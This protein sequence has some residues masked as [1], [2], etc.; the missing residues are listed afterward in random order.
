MRHAPVSCEI[1]DICARACCL[2]FVFFQ[3]ADGRVRCHVAPRMMRH[4]SP[5]LVLR[6]IS[7]ARTTPPAA[8]Q[9]S[10]H[11]AQPSYCNLTAHRACMRVSRRD[12]VYR[13]RRVWCA[14]KCVSSS[15]LPFSDHRV[16]LLRSRFRRV[17]SRLPPHC[18]S[19]RP[20][21]PL[22]FYSA[23][24]CMHPVHRPL[25]VDPAAYASALPRPHAPSVLS[26]DSQTACAHRCLR[27]VVR[28]QVESQIKG[29]FYKS[30]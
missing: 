19:A 22:A 9:D 2:V 17:S 5:V 8:T 13:C 3:A 21:C 18:P 7:M 6:R 26:S 14:L 16:C 1:T 25:R 24:D 4:I 11:P 10:P 28:T 23:H 20:D 15:V 12:L 27:T 29:A 30:L